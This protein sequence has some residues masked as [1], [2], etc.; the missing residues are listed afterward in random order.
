MV[1]VLWASLV[2]VQKALAL[3]ESFI[4]PQNVPGRSTS[5]SQPG[6]VVHVFALN[7]GKGKKHLW[8]I[9][10]DIMFICSYSREA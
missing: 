4:L 10:T 5:R 8:E 2:A 9:Q 7:G 3:V 1:T 6:R